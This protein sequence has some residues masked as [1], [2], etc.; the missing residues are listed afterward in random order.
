MGKIFR[1]Q[2]KF[3][4]GDVLGLKG[5]SVVISKGK[6]TPYN[7]LFIDGI[8]VA[9]LEKG[10]PNFDMNNNYRVYN[11]SPTLA[12]YDMMPDIWDKTRTSLKIIDEIYVNTLQQPDPDDE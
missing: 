3:R 6:K 1:I 5:E 9:T 11:A 2:M 12:L 4:T 10:S 7:Q 8:A